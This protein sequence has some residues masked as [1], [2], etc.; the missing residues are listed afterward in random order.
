M[1]KEL[2]LLV[3][4]TLIDTDILNDKISFCQS[5]EFINTLKTELEKDPNYIQNIKIHLNQ[6]P[7]VLNMLATEGKY[8]LSLIGHSE[9]VLRFEFL[10]WDK[11]GGERNDLL[12]L[13]LYLEPTSRFVGIGESTGCNYGMQWIEGPILTSYEVSQYNKLTLKFSSFSN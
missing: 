11:R 2:F 5:N 12:Y 13:I 9:R 4:P 7:E 6:L 1:D 10:E 8:C 3:Y